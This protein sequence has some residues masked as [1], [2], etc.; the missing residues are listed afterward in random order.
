MVSYDADQRRKMTG[1][2]MLEDSK[3]GD[4]AKKG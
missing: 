3:T 2:M 4:V 1:W